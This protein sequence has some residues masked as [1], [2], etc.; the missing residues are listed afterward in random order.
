MGFRYDET[1]EQR[2]IYCNSYGI[3]CLTGLYAADDSIRITVITQGVNDRFTDR[4]ANDNKAAVELYECEYVQ[5]D[6]TEAFINEKDSLART[7]RSTY[8]NV[9]KNVAADVSLES[10][11]DNFFTPC[12]YLAEKN[13]KA[14]IIHIRTKNS[15]AA[16][17]ANVILCYIKGK[18]NTSIFK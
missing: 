2:G 16:R 7:F 17:V 18:G 12:S 3:N 10:E 15:N 6:Y 5:T 14:D 13:G 8:E 1:E 4:I 9:T 11:T